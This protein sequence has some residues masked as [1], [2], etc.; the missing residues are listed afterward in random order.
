M[1]V[2]SI[3]TGSGKDFVHA[4]DGDDLVIVDGIGDKNLNGG[5]GRFDELRIN[6]NGINS[7][8]D[9]SISND[10]STIIFEDKNSN[11]IRASNFE[12]FKIGN[13]EL[14]TFDGG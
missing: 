12:L 6:L 9:L 13:S 3:T 7:I 4:G 11:K 5:R 1:G 14:N 10:G 2:D 8:K